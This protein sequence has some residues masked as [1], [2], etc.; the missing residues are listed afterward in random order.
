M[1]QVALDH[2]HM[3]T[4]LDHT[5]LY[6]ITCWTCGLFEIIA[7]VSRDFLVESVVCPFYLFYLFVCSR[8]NKGLVWGY[9]IVPNMLYISALNSIS[10]VS[11]S[12]VLVSL[13]GLLC[14][15][16]GIYIFIVL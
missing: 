5:F 3:F 12:C 1:S 16:A 11:F 8:T 7:K 13:M 4:S 14:V 9:L 2:V 15:I 6:H 10:F